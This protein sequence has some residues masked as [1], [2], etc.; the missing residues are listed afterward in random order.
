[1]ARITTIIKKGK[2]QTHIRL[3]HL[4]ELKNYEK[5]ESGTE[6]ENLVA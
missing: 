6:N 3:Q 4:N 2:K 1:M 5:K